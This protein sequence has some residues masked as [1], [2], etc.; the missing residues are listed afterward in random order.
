MTT[1]SSRAEAHSG[2]SAKPVAGPEQRRRKITAVR[3]VGEVLRFQCRRAVTQPRMSVPPAQR[4]IEMVGR[5]ELKAG[6]CRA[7]RQLATR[8]RMPQDRGDVIDSGPIKGIAVVYARGGCDLWV[9]AREC[10]REQ[11]H[12]SQVETRPGNLDWRARRQRGPIDRDHPAR[13]DLQFMIGEVRTAAASQVEIAMGR[14]IDMSR[15]IRAGAVAE[16][17]FAQA[18]EKDVEMHTEGAGV[19]LFAIGAHQRERNTVGAGYR[20]H[21]PYRP[22]ETP[23][24]SVKMIASVVRAE[25]VARSVDDETGPCDPVRI[26][27]ESRAKIGPPRLQIGRQIVKEAVEAENHLVH[28][29]C[30][31]ST[32]DRRDRRT[33][34]HDTHLETRGVGEARHQYLLTRRQAP[35]FPHR[36]GHRHRCERLDRN[37]ATVDPMNLS[38][39]GKSLILTPRASQLPYTRRAVPW[40][41][42]ASS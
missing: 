17:Q 14:Q 27:A 28:D 41:R 4:A 3:T 15:T 5:I 33:V 39:R 16:D 35:P 18:F 11:R 30:A 36:Y 6:G 20:M 26:A 32:A 23:Q 31:V 7:Q 12:I 1:G 13:A 22:I 2:F 42:P 34:V 19:T 24:A 21:R 25:R 9:S 29:F 37:I 40:S 8:R 38:M 10:V